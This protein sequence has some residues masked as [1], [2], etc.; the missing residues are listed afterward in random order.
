[1]HDPN[2]IISFKHKLIKLLDENEDVELEDLILV[3]A[4]YSWD[5]FYFET[6]RELKELSDKV[7][8]QKIDRD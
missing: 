7:R 1:M 2:K 4:S 3:V 5:L 8:D 6:F